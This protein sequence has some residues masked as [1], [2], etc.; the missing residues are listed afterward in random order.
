MFKQET[1][2]TWSRAIARKHELQ[3]RD[4]TLRVY[5]VDMGT[6]IVV[7]IEPRRKG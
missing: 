7:N 1:F 3:L 2:K 6:R 5:V 4:R